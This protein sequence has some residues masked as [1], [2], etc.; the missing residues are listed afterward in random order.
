MEDCIRLI[1]NQVKQHPDLVAVT[2]GD[3]QIS[4]A[5][6]WKKSLLASAALI[7]VKSGPRVL[8]D[9]IQSPEAYAAIVACLH[10]KATY[11]PLSPLAPKER[12]LH[13]KEEFR[14][15]IIIVESEDKKQDYKGSH[16][17]T[18]SELFSGKPVEANTVSYE[19]SDEN[20]IYIIYTSGST[21]MPKGVQI[22]RCALNKFLEWSVPTY[23]VMPGEIWGQFSLLS[24][25]LSIVDIFTC[26]CSG[27]NLLVL[28]D[29]SART[30]PSG[31]IESQKIN[32]WHSIPSAVEFMMQSE[33]S[34]VG[35]FSSLKLMS[36][37]GEKLLKVHLDFLFAKNRNMRIF[38]TYGPTEGTLFCTWKE[39]SAE[40]YLDHCTSTASIGEAIPGWNLQLADNEEQEEKE[41][42]I[43]GD[44]IGRGYL[45]E[46]ADSKFKDITVKDGIKR[47]FATGDLVYIEKD[48]LYFSSR[49]DR[50]V[51]YMGYRLEPAE[52]DYW[53]HHFLGLLSITLLHNNTLY[54]VI[55]SNTTIDE[56]N[57]RLSL[58]E[59]LESYKIPR[60]FISVSAMPRNANMKVDH[61]ELIKLLL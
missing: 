20:I 47:T 38:N 29:P 15:D 33:E 39:M 4:Y 56:Q 41:V 51:K 18:V 17:V 26:L 43:T 1:E 36:F 58:N 45:G 9:I 49:K 6:F 14:P 44:F 60:Y 40:N 22:A 61:S 16:V 5:E 27:G 7:A 21:G 50:Q 10:S 53:I 37:C 59:Q 31:V 55:E 11:C 35:N 42:I 34:R 32:Y 2:E 48:E 57:L 12:K 24:F 30:R 23:G 3:R 54:A 28:K 8:L 52:I 46:V 19:G 13:I 25:D